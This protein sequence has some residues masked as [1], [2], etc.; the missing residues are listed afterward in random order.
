[1]QGLIQRVTQAKVEVDGEVV[2]E[3]SKGILLLLG[4]EKH[5]TEQSAEKLL[6]KVSNYR[7][8]TD[9][10]GKM[11][12]SLQDIQGELLVVSQF[13]LAADT[14]KGMRP[15]FSSAATPAQANALYEYFVEKAKAVDLRVA[16]GQFAADMQVSLCN[17]GPVT[18]NLSV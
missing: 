2:G 17:D 7:I 1:M 10:Q 15:S 18:F 11:N 12:L 14:K 13:T 16:T 9:Q 4:V 6:H 5:D 8:F 3:I